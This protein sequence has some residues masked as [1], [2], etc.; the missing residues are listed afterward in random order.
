MEKVGNPNTLVNLIA[1]RVRQL[2]GG[3]GSASRPLVTETAGMGAADISLT[4]IIEGKLSWEA[5]EPEPKKAEPVTRK[6]R[7][8]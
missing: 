7:R 1:R 6:R 2:N 3:G 5:T 4:E 8:S